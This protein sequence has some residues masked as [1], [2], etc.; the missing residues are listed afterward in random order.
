MPYN[1]FMNSNMARIIFKVSFILLAID[2]AVL[3]ISPIVYPVSDRYLAAFGWIALVLILVS[4]IS[5][6]VGRRK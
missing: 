4:A 1:E 6:I 3:A 2:L 5:W